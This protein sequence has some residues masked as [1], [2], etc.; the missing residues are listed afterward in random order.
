M[1]PRKSSVDDFS[2]RLGADDADGR[3]GCL[4]TGRPHPNDACS[5]AALTTKGDFDAQCSKWGLCASKPARKRSGRF[6]P[7]CTRYV[8][9]RI[10]GQR[11]ARGP[12][13]CHSTS[14][15]IIEWLTDNGSGYI[16]H[17]TEHFARDITFEPC[18]TP[19]DFRLAPDSATVYSLLYPAPPEPLSKVR[20][21]APPIRRPQRSWAGR[22]CRGC[23]YRPAGPAI[24]SA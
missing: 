9:P 18:A 17:D 3:R 12:K 14:R 13:R 6:R 10:G 11:G 2:D 15:A 5:R 23:P 7:S 24:S 20:R 1:W 4:W 21:L 19:V 16:A 22:F 8:V